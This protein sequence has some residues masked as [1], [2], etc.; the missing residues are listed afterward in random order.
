MIACF[1]S[2]NEDDVPNTYEN[3]EVPAVKN[4]GL[5]LLDL[6]KSYINQN[7]INIDKL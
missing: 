2:K 3:E 7:G 6:L 5:A 4:K 1:S